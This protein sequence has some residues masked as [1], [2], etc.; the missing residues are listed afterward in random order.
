MLEKV[1]NNAYKIDFLGEYGV[2]YTFNVAD[3]KPYYK[4]DLLE[5]LRESSFQQGE[6]DAPMED[7]DD[8]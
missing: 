8:G 7:N 2:S 6:D 5:H 1:N 4:N 3:L